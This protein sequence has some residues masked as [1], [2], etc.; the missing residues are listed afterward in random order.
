[1]II[2]PIVTK[3]QLIRWHKLGWIDDEGLHLDKA[4]PRNAEGKLERSSHQYLS[5][6]PFYR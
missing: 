6:K 5:R 1:L 4:F 3:E 2:A